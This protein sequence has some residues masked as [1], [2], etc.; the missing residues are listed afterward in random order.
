MS[1]EHCPR[2]CP[3]LRTTPVEELCTGCYYD[4]AV[5]RNEEFRIGGKTYTAKFSV[6]EWIYDTEGIGHFKKAVKFAKFGKR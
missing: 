3:N 5:S 4:G 6:G 2:T 1:S